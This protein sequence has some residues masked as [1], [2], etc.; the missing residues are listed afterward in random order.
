MSPSG[1]AETAVVAVELTPAGGEKLL[2]F[3]SKNVGRRMAIVVDG[4]VM[5]APR[6]IS[7]ISGGHLQ[8]TMGAGD[9]EEQIAQAEHLAD[10]LMGQTSPAGSDG[11]RR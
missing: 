8:I 3:T 10:V 5:S 9:V 2:R 7:P 1:G 11:T 6:I 4:A